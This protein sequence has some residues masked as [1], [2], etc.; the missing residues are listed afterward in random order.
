MIG[1]MGMF[2]GLVLTVG[3]VISSSSLLVVV[4]SIIL[5]VGA[6]GAVFGVGGVIAARDSRLLMLSP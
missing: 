6:V 1:T 3:V 2:V 4:V 5:V